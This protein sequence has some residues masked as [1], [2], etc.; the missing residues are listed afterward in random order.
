MTLL[1]KILLKYIDKKPMDLG[2]HVE[3]TY[4]ISAVI[5]MMQEYHE[6][7]MEDTLKDCNIKLDAL[8]T[9]DYRFV[10]WIIYSTQHK[11]F[12]A[13]V[14]TYTNDEQN[15]QTVILKGVDTSPSAALDKIH[16]TIKDWHDKGFIPLSD[17][18]G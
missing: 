5:D 16:A 8:R 3:R 13:G 10:A 1:S 18:V 6:G 4:P 2:S 9:K 11:C 12:I 15:I 7:K 17:I 14:D